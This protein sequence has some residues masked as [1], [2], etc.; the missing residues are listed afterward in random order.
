MKILAVQA[1]EIHVTMELSITT[2]RSML[3]CMDKCV[4]EIDMNETD[5]QKAYAEFKQFYEFLD[6]FNKGIGDGSVE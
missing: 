1:K 4:V 5:N 6:E 3:R 2:V